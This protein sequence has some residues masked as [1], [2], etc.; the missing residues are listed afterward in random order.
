MKTKFLTFIMFIA[1]TSGVTFAQITD[2]TT[3]TS[4]PQI[5]MS[6]AYREGL[7]GGPGIVTSESATVNQLP[8]QAQDF[9][10][11]VYSRVM[12][13]NVNHNVVADT[14][15]VT[16]GNGV[17]IKFDAAGKVQDIQAPYPDSLYIPAIE[18][19]LPTKAF[20]HLEQAGLL[21]EVTGIK[22]ATGKGLRVQLLNATPPEMLF[23][24]DGL[25]II[26][27]D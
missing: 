1:L 20:K 24:L 12:V 22:N 16:L 23:D 7:F 14:Y 3:N 8:T 26:V 27:D 2:S 9:L 4:T 13:T 21:Y 10:Q 6:Q 25:F 18:A 19:T 17:K 15:D 11:E 5:D